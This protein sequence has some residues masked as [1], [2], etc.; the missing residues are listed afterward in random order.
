M[1]CD[2]KNKFEITDKKDRGFIQVCQL[3]IKILFSTI[4]FT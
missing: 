3:L 2:A 4:F 1:Q